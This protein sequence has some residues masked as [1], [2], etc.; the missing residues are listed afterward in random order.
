MVW[1]VVLM[2]YVTMFCYVWFSPKNSPHKKAGQASKTS[3]NYMLTDHFPSRKRSVYLEP[4]WY[5]FWF[6]KPCSEVLTFKNR[7][8]L[9]SRKCTC[10]IYT[11]IF[12]TFEK[13]HSCKVDFCVTLSGLAQGLELGESSTSSISIQ[14]LEWPPHPRGPNM[15]WPPWSVEDKLYQFKALN[16]LLVSFC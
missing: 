3:G 4:K 9:G 11:Y 1:H 16:V 7:V 14:A 10:H 6:E 8:H 5:L 13:L 2:Q 12:P 15:K